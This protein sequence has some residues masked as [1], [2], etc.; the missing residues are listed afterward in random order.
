MSFHMKCQVIRSCKTSL[1]YFT[2]ER[3]RARMFTVMSSKFIR[4]CKPPLTFRPVTAIWF[5]ACMDPL[6]G[7]QMRTFCVHFRTPG[8][9]TMVNSSFFQFRIVSTIVLEGSNSEDIFQ[10]FLL[11]VL[12]V[13]LIRRWWMGQ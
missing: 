13:S 10:N 6:M 8:V 3:F 7:F 9:I 1:T 2:F 12:L 11:Q 5:F 4:S